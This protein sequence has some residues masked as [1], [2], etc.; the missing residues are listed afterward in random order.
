MLPYERREDGGPYTCPCCRMP[1]LDTRCCYEIC[2]EC[3]WEDDGQDDHNADR[4]LGGPNGSLSLTEAR[5]RYS[6][7]ISDEPGP[8]SVL[9]GG[10][11]LWWAAARERGTEAAGG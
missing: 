6:E 5:R 11:G 4:V 2:V 3:G 9:G 8:E 10:A 1:M 7:A